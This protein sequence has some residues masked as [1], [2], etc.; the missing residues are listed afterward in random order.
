MAK[1]FI[2]G[3][4]LCGITVL[5]WAFAFDWPKPSASGV[6]LLV[7]SCLASRLRVKLPGLTGTMSVNLPF[8]LLAV[9]TL[10]ISESM[11]V[12]CVSTLTQCL[13]AALKKFNAIQAA[14]NVCNMA[15][16]VT[17]TRLILGSETLAAFVT[18][19]PLRL[20]TAAAGYFL[21]N[22]IPVAIIISMTE[23][24]SVVHTWA[25][26]FQ[27]SFP[28]Y[29]ASAGIAGIVLT[30]AKHIGWLQPMAMLLIMFGVLHSY[31]CYFS[32]A[33]RPGAN[34]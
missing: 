11:V 18:P 24:C 8:I 19:H 32:Q 20:V 10:S 14:F 27:L 25:G 21:V 3:L 5:V 15:L 13:P 23:R 26:M 2:A 28:Y 16:A 12:G 33:S 9:A 22:T 4:V 29:V 30:L 34:S 1:A 31:R 6:A 7:V 17:A